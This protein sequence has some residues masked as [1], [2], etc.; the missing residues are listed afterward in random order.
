MANSNSQDLSKDTERALDNNIN[1]DDDNDD[2]GLIL[3][4]INI[5]K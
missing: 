3:N 4:K 5:F 2:D 1:F